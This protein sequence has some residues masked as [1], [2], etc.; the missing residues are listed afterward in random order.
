MKPSLKGPES[1][2]NPK[3]INKAKEV[4]RKSTAYNSVNDELVPKVHIAEKSETATAIPNQFNGDLDGLNEKVKSMMEKSYNMV[5]NGKHYNGTPKHKRGFICKVCG[6]EGHIKNI[7]DHIEAN[8]LEGILIPCDFCG[9]P[10]GSRNALNKH[11]RSKHGA[12]MKV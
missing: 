1:Q 2:A 8:H 5:P 3:S 12:E 7:R 4:F 6:K 11:R 9:K 10:L